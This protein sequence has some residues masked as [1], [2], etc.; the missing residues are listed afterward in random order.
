[1][2]LT[3]LLFTKYKDERHCGIELATQFTAFLVF[4]ISAFL[5][6]SICVDRYFHVNPNF[7]KLTKLAEKLFT[8]SRRW[9]L[10]RINIAISMLLAS[11][12]VITSITGHIDI[13]DII[14]IALNGIA[15]AA[16]FFFYCIARMKLAI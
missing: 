6:L 3:L 16:I 8:G 9:Y 4:Q 10:I 12:T 7:E 13:L 14:I 11:M 15:L 5:T 2:V 1:M